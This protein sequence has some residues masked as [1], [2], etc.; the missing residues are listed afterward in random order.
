MT[1]LLV[2]GAASGAS[3]VSIEEER[4][5][6]FYEDALKQL[7]SGN[8]AAAIIQLRNA[9]Q[10]NPDNADARLLLGQLYLQAGDGPSA[11]K[12]L[13]RA[14][15]ARPSDETEIL[16][17]N[18]L[19]MQQ[20]YDAV[21]SA[22]SPE[23]AT[24]ELHRQKILLRG[25][26]H[27]GL[28]E[29]EKAEALYREILDSDPKA[30]GAHFALAR[31]Q[32]ARGDLETARD[33]LQTALDIDPEFF[34][35]W[36]L[37]AEMALRERQFAGALD[38][39]ERANR[40]RPGDT[41][42]HLGRAQ[43]LLQTGKLEE[44]EREVAAVLERQPDHR[45][46]KYLQAGVHFARGEYNE[47]DRLYL[48]IQDE[49][50]DFIP[51]LLLGGLI[52]FSTG[53]YA[54]ANDMLTRYVRAQPQNTAAKRLLALVHLRQGEPES[55]V[56]LL[57]PLVQEH[58][59]DAAALQ[60][61][62][63]GYMRTARYDEAA[64]IFEQIERSGNPAVVQ[65][66]RTALTLLGPSLG[67]G[68]I[69][70]GDVPSGEAPAGESAGA[71]TAARQAALPEGE[72]LQPDDLSRR[73]LL[74]L[75]YL[76][77]RDFDAALEEVERLKSQHPDN[78]VVLNIEGGVHVARG[79]EETARQRFEEA[80][81]IN[82]DFLSALSN[83]D[84]L[85]LRAGNPEA[86]ENRMRDRLERN[87][88]DERMTL[89][90]A[91]F[92]L[93]QG[94]PDETYELLES[95]RAAMP[96]SRAVRRALIISYLRNGQREPV[97]PVAR[98]LAEMA[99]D[100]AETIAFA[101]GALFDAGASAESAELFQTAAALQPDSERLQL[102]LAD[103]LYAADRKD[104]AR[105]V[106]IDLQAKD[107]GNA[108]AAAGLINFAMSEERPEEALRIA[109]RL[110]AD[111][112]VAAAQLKSDVLMR[113]GRTGEAV[114]VLTQAF[115]EN[116]VS[117]LAIDLFLARRS[118]GEMD[119]AVANLKDWVE[120]HED[121]HSARLAL[122]SA[123][124]E[125][126]D[127]EA[128]AQHYERLAAVNP[129]DAAVLNNLAWLKNELNQPNALDYA[130]RARQ[131][132]PSSPE[133]ADTLGWLLVQSAQTPEGLELLREAASAAPTNLDIQ[134]HLAYALHAAGDRDAALAILEKLLATD[135]PFTEREAA[136]L[137]LTEL[138]G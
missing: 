41:R 93:S 45:F 44:G 136:K 134:Y 119:A 103:A 117:S 101:A 100:D 19:L 15:S 124:L 89:R 88:K 14:L 32:A 116:P 23:A 132:A 76:R 81:A 9:L 69:P 92:L 79:D 55:A 46:A 42:V 131:L 59:D 63:S 51:G 127:Y 98:E 5:R 18:A 40:I 121:D 49:M 110:K 107:P 37:K 111:N 1:A 22:I 120:S 138:R 80:L 12:E 135:Q 29:P 113:L 115:Q 38:A 21:L 137:L 78:P 30:V 108:A 3:A 85:D 4:S 47:A 6:S 133:I 97:V 36:L 109:D 72:L 94:R 70:A 58:P 105:Q 64:K 114:S 86:V 61:L 48:T 50:R 33:T 27:F 60:L 102:A 57:E 73:I 90:L 84:R 83:L 24:P 31:L 17:G 95:A 26:A 106:L 99:L 75:D 87:P 11:E 112:A 118:A 28:G 13:R 82:P 8:A 43:A 123:L 20:K 68:E 39:L 34:D 91:E 126:G 56:E 128:A 96:D 66:A 77:T 25:N 52:K 104:E 74:V 7:E 65:Q 35:G 130:R 53:Q 125:T 54:Q 122:A 10:Q 16:L 2:L 129:N 67:I 71:E 62:A